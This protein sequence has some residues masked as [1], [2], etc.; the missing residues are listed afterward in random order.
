ISNVI[1][2][3][4]VVGLALEK[5]VKPNQYQKGIFGNGVGLFFS[6]L[7]S[8]VG[9][10]PLAISAGFIMTTGIK[11]LLPLIIGAILITVSGF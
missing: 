10:I 4:L 7:F 1:S 9:V 2:S 3:V 6:G 8:V 5:R 11:K